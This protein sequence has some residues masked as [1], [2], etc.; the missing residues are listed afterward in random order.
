MCK[1]YLVDFCP[2]ELFVNTRA[3]LGKPASF[4]F[5]SIVSTVYEPVHKVLILLVADF[6][7]HN[8]LA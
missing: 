3:D 8:F 5:T 2:S 4:Q 1:Y 7:K 6:D